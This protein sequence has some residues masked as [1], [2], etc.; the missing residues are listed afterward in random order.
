MEEFRSI[1]RRLS[2][3]GRWGEGDERGALN[4]ITPERVVAAGGLVRQGKVFS[5]GIALDSNG[6][7]AGGFRHNPVRLMAEIGAGMG[8]GAFRFSDDWVIMA[9]QAATHWDAIAHVS[10]DDQL[11]NG[12]AATTTDVHGA[13][14]NGIDKAAK[15]GIAGR[16]VLVDMA[17]FNRVDWMAPAEVITPA[18]LDAACAAQGVEVRAGDIL[19]LR[20][21]WWKKFLTDGD[22]TG[23]FV[24]EPGLGMACADWLR[25]R[26]V[27]AVCADNFGVEAMPS[28]LEGEMYPLHLVLIRDMGLMFGELFD[29]E[30]LAHD[31]AADGVYE[32]LFA[33]PP[34]PFTNG[35]GSP[36]NPLAIK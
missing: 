8:T 24:G 22:R 34:L 13:A 29:V 28:E 14:R 23:W 21:G 35:A 26:D 11:Y 31:C 9:L 30:S 32:F 4:T 2:N 36:V 3:W 7:H 16:G 18:D 12:F 19:V 10:Y 15:N 27:A 6:P 1:G 17:R 5:M 33:G 20:T 25:A